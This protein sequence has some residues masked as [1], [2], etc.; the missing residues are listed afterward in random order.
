MDR[1]EK[2]TSCASHVK[3]NQRKLLPGFFAWF[4]NDGPYVDR[5]LL[6]CFTKE[7]LFELLTAATLAKNYSFLEAGKHMLMI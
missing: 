7:Y 2:F 4:C 5:R 3:Q 1:D 6:P